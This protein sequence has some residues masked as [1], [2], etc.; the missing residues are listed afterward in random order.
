MMTPEQAEAYIADLG[1]HLSIARVCLELA[2]LTPKHFYMS[3][4]L[5]KAHGGQTLAGTLAIAAWDLDREANG[6]SVT[7]EVEVGDGDN[8]ILFDIMSP[9]MQMPTAGEDEVDFS[10]ALAVLKTLDEERLPKAIG[11]LVDVGGGLIINQENSFM[12]LQGKGFRAAA[13]ELRKTVPIDGLHRFTALVL[14][15][16]H[17]ERGFVCQ[18]VSTRANTPF[19]APERKFI[20]DER[21]NMNEDYLK[22]DQPA[23]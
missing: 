8:R 11:R 21:M 4:D 10:E 9:Y 20:F 12:P 22:P 7:G 18:I 16:A 5:I 3:N 23:D 13:M 1:S 2:P 17:P 14:N 6:K 19:V 15:A